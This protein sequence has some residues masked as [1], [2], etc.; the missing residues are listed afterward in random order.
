M[1]R[2]SIVLIV[3]LGCYKGRQNAVTTTGCL[4]GT[5]TNP[6]EQLVYL[7]LQK[8]HSRQWTS[9]KCH[10]VDFHLTRLRRLNFERP[11]HEVAMR[12]HLPDE[13]ELLAS[14]IAPRY[15]AI[16]LIMAWVTP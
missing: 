12:R 6:R 3:S 1:L 14:A 4:L 16:V 11:G 8:H 2:L 10:R 5:S 15:R 7:C 9:V 13:L